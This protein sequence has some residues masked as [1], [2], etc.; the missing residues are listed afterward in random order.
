MVL[1]SGAIAKY[2]CYFSKDILFGLLVVTTWREPRFTD[3][4]RSKISNIWDFL[5][6]S[7]RHRKFD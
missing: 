4:I 7:R 1:P 5:M 3:Q 2:F 6:R